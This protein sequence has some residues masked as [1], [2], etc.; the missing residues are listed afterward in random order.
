MRLQ[1]EPGGRL[2]LLVGL[3]A[4]AT[5]PEFQPRQSEPATPPH[6]GTELAEFSIP[7]PEKSRQS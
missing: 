5:V 4:A 6:S 3:I 7:A 1:E 2:L